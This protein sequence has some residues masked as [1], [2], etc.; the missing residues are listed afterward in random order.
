M[1]V[2]SEMQL[3]CALALDKI[4]LKGRYIRKLADLQGIG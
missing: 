1:R 2:T 3:K 4:I